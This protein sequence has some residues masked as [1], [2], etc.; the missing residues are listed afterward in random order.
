[1][2]PRALL[3]DLRR[4]G[5]TLWLDNDK[6]RF[7]GTQEPLSPDLLAELKSNKPDL[8]RILADENPSPCATHFGDEGPPKPYLTQFGNLAIPFESDPRY[9]W[10]KPGG[11][12]PSEVQE[13]LKRLVN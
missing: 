2:R 12:K 4:R 3:D 13:E 6:I 9:H 1:M 10:W 7:K 8:I 5:F 11:R